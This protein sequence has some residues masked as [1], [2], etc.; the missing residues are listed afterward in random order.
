MFDPFSQIWLPYLLIWLP[1]RRFA[2]LGPVLY[3]VELLIVHELLSSHHR[4]VEQ[5]VFCFWEQIAQIKEIFLA[6]AH[7]HNIR[8]ES[9]QNLAGL[10]VIMLLFAPERFEYDVGL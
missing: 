10:G 2:P 5:I 7:E 9:M 8:V 4:N 3:R 6:H 1:H